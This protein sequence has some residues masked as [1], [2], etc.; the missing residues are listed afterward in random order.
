MR[1]VWAICCFLLLL[2]ITPAA[3]VAESLLVVRSNSQDWPPGTMIDGNAVLTLGEGVQLTLLSNDGLSTTVAGPYAAAPL[4][5]R[6][7]PRERGLVD[8][9]SSLL[10]S[11]S[12]DETVIGGFRAPDEDREALAWTID[13]ILL[14]VQSRVVCRDSA[15]M[16]T[17]ARPEKGMNTAPTVLESL[18]SPGWAELIFPAGA[19]VVPWPD[20][21]QTKDGARFRLTIGGQSAPAEFAVAI[22][23][24][25]L[26]TPAHRAAWM[27]EHGCRV[28]AR[29]LILLSY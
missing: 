15:R 17:F 11:S 28:Q 22:L 5:A 29:R 6:P 27:A 24:S 26:Q 4:Q 16:L 13:A 20:T 7:A 3:A 21:V 19:T 25:D 23:P 2:A 1:T 9:L 12:V 14:A 18:G 8:V 10:T